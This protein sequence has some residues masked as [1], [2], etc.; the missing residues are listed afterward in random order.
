MPRRP[1]IP[2]S[3]ADQVVQVRFTANDVHYLDVARGD[4]P[5]GTWIRE[6][7]RSQTNRVRTDA[8]RRSQPVS[9]DPAADGAAEV[10]APRGRPHDP[11]EPP[12]SVGKH[13]HKPGKFLAARTVKGVTTKTYRCEHEGCTHELER[14]S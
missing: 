14:T 11:S 2:G 1:D 9:G 3:P 6:L 8:P 7:V 13:R 4:M 12:T 5:R 10:K